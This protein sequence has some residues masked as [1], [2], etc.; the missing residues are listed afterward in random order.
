MSRGRS[1]GGDRRR[2][3]RWLGTPYRHQAALKGVGCDCLGL[4]RGVWRGG[5]RRASPSRSRPT[6]PT[7][8]RRRGDETLAEAAAA[9]H[10]RRC[11]S[12]RPAGR[13]APLPLARAPPAKHRGILVAPRPLRPRPPGRGGRRGRRS[14]PWWRR[15]RRLRL[16]VP[17]A[18]A[19]PMATHRPLHRRRG[20]RRLGS[21]GSRLRPS[22]GGDRPRRRRASPA[23]RHRPVA[24]RRRSARS[25]PGASSDLQ[26]HRPRP[27]ARRS[28]ASTARC[29]STGEM[30]WATRFEESA[31][32]RTG[33]GG[34]GGVERDEVTEYRYFATSRSGSA[35]GRSP[36]S[37]ASGPTA[38]RSSLDRRHS[39]VSTAAR[40]DQEPDRLI[41]A[42]QGDGD[43]PAYR[44]HGLCRLRA[45]AARDVRQPRAAVLLR[46][47][48]PGPAAARRE[49]GAGGDADPR[50][51]RVRLRPTEV[52]REARR[53]RRHARRTTTTPS[54]AATDCTARSSE[55]ED[56]LP[57]P[58]ERRA[59]RRLVRQRPPRR[60]LRDPAGRR[61][62]GQGHRRRSPGGARRRPREAAHLV[63]QHEGRPAYGGTPSD[64]TVVAAIRDLKARGLKV[65]LL[66][67]RDDGRAARQRADRPLWRRRAGGLS[68][69]RA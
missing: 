8:P 4:V 19:D 3:A 41:E 55:L 7:G 11:R 66:S 15:R 35:R 34:K 18:R 5:L 57:E 44:G 37:A 2:G 28:R 26:R 38:S 54:R 10:A 63:S 27:R 58:R 68:L 69:A 59:G 16:P 45:A 29:A 51:D 53:R 32:R 48:P 42:K 62:R 13:R 12:P 64:A 1:R 65:M 50:R 20:A 52:V 6:P 67:L 22:G 39:G 25:R 23:L 40:E 24:A 46:G 56:L 43:A 36:A 47:D 49:P 14:T 17:G 30:I 33:G 60:P 9:A 31:R 21:G 61:G